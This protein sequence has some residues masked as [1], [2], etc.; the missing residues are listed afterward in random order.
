MLPRKRAYL[1][2]VQYEYVAAAAQ[3][4]SHRSQIAI[5]Q[6]QES[7]IAQREQAESTALDDESSQDERQPETVDA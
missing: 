6:V 4:Q 2:V 7:R 5:K 3:V 1:H